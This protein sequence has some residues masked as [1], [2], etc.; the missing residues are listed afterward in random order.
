MIES[1]CNLGD[2]AI[3]NNPTLFYRTTANVNIAYLKVISALMKVDKK[4]K[5]DDYNWTNYPRAVATLVSGQRDY[6]LPKATTGGDSSTLLKV[7]KV[8]VLNKNTTPQ[9]IMLTLTDMEEGELNNIWATSGLPSYYRVIGNSIKLW[10][11]PDNNVTVTLTSGL[12]V[13]FQRTHTPFD[14]STTNTVEPGF[15]ATY[16]DLLALDAAATYFLPINT[17][18]AINYANLFSQRLELMQQDY[19]ERLD[20]VHSVIRPKYRNSK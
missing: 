7:E 16:H 9:E 20:D 15:M 4:W 5:W 18:M 19:V 17:Q 8:A 2:G 3:S 11:A 10:P 6:T 14:T 13:Y 12:I 1:L